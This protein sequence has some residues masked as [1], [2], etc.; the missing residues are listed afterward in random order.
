MREVVACHGSDEPPTR[1]GRLEHRGHGS[2][3]LSLAD[4]LGRDVERHRS[5]GKSPIAE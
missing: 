5:L 4:C 2:G 1:I 3:G